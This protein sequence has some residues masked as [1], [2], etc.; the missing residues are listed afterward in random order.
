MA[1]LAGVICTS[2]RLPT[3]RWLNSRAFNKTV[4]ESFTRERGTKFP[5]NNSIS[6]WSA[7]ITQSKYFDIKNESASP[8]EISIPSRTAS[9]DQRY[10]T[11][12]DE[13]PVVS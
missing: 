13:P 2:S 3:R 7:A 6:C 5:K 8:T 12:H 1:D 4:N 10:R 11:S 9:G